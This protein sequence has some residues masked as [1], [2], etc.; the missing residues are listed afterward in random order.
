MPTFRIGDRVFVAEDHCHG[1]IRKGITH[2]LGHFWR[3]GYSLLQLTMS[4]PPAAAVR[5][6]WR[7]LRLTA[8]ELPEYERT[9]GPTRPQIHARHQKEDS[10]PELRGRWENGRFQQPVIERPRGA[11]AAPGTPIGLGRGAPAVFRLPS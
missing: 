2:S 9:H 5:K 4:A 8:F 7:K 1:R 6:W 10:L 3:L 11:A